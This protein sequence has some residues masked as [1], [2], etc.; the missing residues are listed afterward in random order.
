MRQAAWIAIVL[1]SV[2]LFPATAGP[3][4]ANVTFA[5]GSDYTF[6]RIRAT[7]PTSDEGPIELVVYVYRP[8]KKD[9][10]EIVIFNHGST[11]GW[12]VSPQE[13]TF[14]PERSIVRF[15]IQ[16]GYT[17]VAP[18]RRGV[19]ES[20]GSYREECPYQ[21]GRCSLAESRAMTEP[22]L[23]EAT[24]DV[25]AVIDQLVL[26]KLVP[27]DSRILLTGQS[28]GAF[29]SLHHAGTRPKVVRGVIGFVGGWL[30][31]TDSWP[32]AENAAR[33]QLQ[34]D[35][36][37]RA[38][39]QFAAPTLWIYGA[40][41]SFLTEAT[42]RQFF[43]AFTDAGGKGEYIFISNHTLDNGHTIVRDLALWESAVDSYLK[44]L[45]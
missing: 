27:P 40:R 43:Q 1:V 36:L 10:R 8:L 22:A 37:A 24:R 6:E 3:Q 41:D 30:S 13:P 12:V 16:R 34:K 11:G 44:T 25:D 39:K 45:P 29:L 21:G 26:G 9:R 19:G 7:R 4:A 15:F 38:G 23:V 42:T 17:V 18:M 28:R 32:A 14:N 31:I 33:L 2:L 35:L 5:H 20:A